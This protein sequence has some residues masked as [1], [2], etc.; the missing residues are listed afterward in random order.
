MSEM[1]DL[2]MV[3]VRLE[4]VAKHLWVKQGMEA[5]QLREKVLE[6]LLPDLHHGKHITEIFACKMVGRLPQGI[7]QACHL[8]VHQQ[9]AVCNLWHSQVF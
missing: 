3:A 9:T 5:F 2:E 7:C 4:G 8:P 6:R 1:Q